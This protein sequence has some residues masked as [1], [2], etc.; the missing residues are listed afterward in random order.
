MRGKGVRVAL[1][2]FD[3]MGVGGHRNVLALESSSSVAHSR[4]RW[5][6][7]VGNRG[8]LLRARDWIASPALSP[9]REGPAEDRA[10]RRRRGRRCIERAPPCSCAHWAL[11]PLLLGQVRAESAPSGHVFCLE[12][13]RTGV[14]ASEREGEKEEEGR[15]RGGSSPQQTKGDFDR[16]NF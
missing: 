9:P 2:L 3:A 4:S 13:V 1:L 14:R 12:E 6:T 15:R 7:Q 8:F 5:I 11:R 16:E 10:R